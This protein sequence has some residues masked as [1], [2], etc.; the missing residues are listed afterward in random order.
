MSRRWVLGGAKELVSEFEFAGDRHH[1]DLDAI[2]LHLTSIAHAVQGD[3]AAL[4][5]GAVFKQA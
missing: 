4:R 2:H 3:R 5:A 1:V